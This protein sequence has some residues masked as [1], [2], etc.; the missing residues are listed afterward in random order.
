MWAV[1]QV[2]HGSAIFLTTSPSVKVIAAKEGVIF[3]PDVFS[4]YI[5]DAKGG[6]EVF[7]E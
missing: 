6:G 5:L 2:H 4:E 7:R 3:Q 1:I